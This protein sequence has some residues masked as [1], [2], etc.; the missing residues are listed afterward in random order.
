[1]TG[2]ASA[3]QYNPGAATTTTPWLTDLAAV[4]DQTGAKDPLIV[5]FS[6]GG[7]EVA[8]YMSRHNGNSVAK[9]ALVTTVLLDFLKR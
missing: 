5:G 7:G 4:I 2:A 3:A 6:M 8:R 1:M 9:A